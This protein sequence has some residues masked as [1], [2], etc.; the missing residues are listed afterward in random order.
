[1]HECSQAHRSLAAAA[2]IVLLT[3]CG[4]SGP[5]PSGVEFVE[6]PANGV[7]L[8]QGGRRVAIYGDPRPEPAAAEAV[9]LTHARRDVVWEALP[10][11][12][13]GAKV[14]APAGERPLLEDVASYWQ[15]YYSEGRFHDYA[16]QS[17]RILAE[18]LRVDERVSGD[19]TLFDGALPVRVLETPG[20]TRK[21]VTYLFEVE[22]KRLA[23]TGDLI[24]GDGKIHDLFSLQDAIPEANVRGYH[25]YAARAA[26]VINSLRKLQAEKPDMLLPA[27]GPLITN[28]EEA[29]G[30]LIARM[31]TL[32]QAY[33]KTDALRWYWGDDN[34]RLRASRVLSDAAVE[35]MP[36][37]NE[38]REIPPRWMHK[39]NTSRLI[40][41]DD[42]PAFLI[43]CGTDQVM[44]Q[45]EDLRSRGV[46]TK[47]EGIFVTHFHDDHTDRV[48]AMAEKCDCPVYS[49]PE[50]ADILER[51]GAY[52]MPAMTD[53]PIAGVRVLEEGEK[54]AWHEYSFTYTYF[55]GQAVYHGGLKME[56]S[57][58]EKLFFVGDSFS[59]SG[60]DDYCLQNRHFLHSNLG[61]YRCLR[62]IRESDPAYWLVNQHIEPVFRYSPEQLDFMEQTLE[63][64]QEAVADLV[65][66]EDPNFGLDEQWARLYPYGRQARAGEPLEMWAVVFNHANEPRTF[67]F[68]PHAPQGWQVEPVT[69]TVE[70]RQEGRAA[71][72]VTPAAT[73]L[74]VV[75]ADVSMGDRMLPQWAE[76]L[77]EVSSK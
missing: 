68:T 6:G 38:L 45:I 26:D 11:A 49:G 77:I 56:R 8:T 64:K 3:A 55:P 52:Q 10:L 15:A 74:T 31:Q 5:L 35:W 30:K 47:I 51:P 42:G 32:F 14:Y 58:G 41:S 63:A 39:F 59:P 28:P 18:P 76:T 67:T 37:A 48:Q 2:L 24:W 4:P 36:M 54:L 53:I 29:I 72:R 12:K 25:G 22:G 23:A 65:P 19:F 60:L 75:T 50:T 33:Y 13:A 9:L 27:R 66:W 61:H 1:M 44:Q 69:L 70:P 43:D 62:I 17:S 71:M 73:G 20:Y 16:E 57:D 46:F 34:L 7:I 21:S 40:V